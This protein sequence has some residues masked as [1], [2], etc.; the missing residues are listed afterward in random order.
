MELDWSEQSP[1]IRSLYRPWQPGD[2]YEEAEIQAAETRLGFR[3]PA[4]LRNF[5]RAWGKRKDLIDRQQSLLEPYT[6]M[7]RAGAL[8][9]FAENQGCW[10]WA[11]Q[12]EALEEDN[13]PIVVGDPVLGQVG[14]EVPSPPWR[15]SHAQLS[16]LLDDIIYQHAFYFGGAIHGGQTSAF[17]HPP[18]MEQIAWLEQHWRKATVTPM[19]FG[20]CSNLD[21]AWQGLPLYVRDGQAIHWWELA[22]SIVAREAEALDEIAETLQLTWAKRW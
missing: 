6:L 17:L 2:G 15:Q 10:L 20:L 11:V 4:T 12:C 18:T 14:W 8:I 7:I 5:Y 13:P 3:L 16:S 9:V 1:H 22:C 19:G 21:A